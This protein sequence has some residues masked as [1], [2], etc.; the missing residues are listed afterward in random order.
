[1]IMTRSNLHVTLSNGKEIICVSD[2][3][4]AP[5]Q[6]YIVEKLFLP[7]L[8]S[9]NYGKEL[10]LLT[11]LCSMDDRRVN[12]TYRYYIN[13]ITKEVRMFEEDYNYKT[14]RF[15]KGQ[16]LTHRYTSYVEKLKSQDHGKA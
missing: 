11:D 3:S 7:L 1:M 15:C 6:G 14:D 13:L 16:D 10:D 8:A 5:E 4:S 9:E 12:A 2:S